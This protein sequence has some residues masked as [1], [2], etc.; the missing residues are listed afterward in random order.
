MD[1]RSQLAMLKE[2]GSENEV[3]WRMV[4]S[5]VASIFPAEDPLSNFVSIGSKLVVVA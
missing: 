2:D 5:H 4:S 3:S 1:V